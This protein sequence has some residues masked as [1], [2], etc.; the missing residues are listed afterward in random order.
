MNAENQE[1]ARIYFMGS[2]A[3]FVAGL[4][5]GLFLGFISAILVMM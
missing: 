3:G 4:L 1:K 5:L 2:Q